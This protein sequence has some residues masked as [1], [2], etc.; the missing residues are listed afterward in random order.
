MWA[1]CSARNLGIIHSKGELVVFVDDTLSFP[2]DWLERM[3]SWYRRGYNPVSIYNWKDP[4]GEILKHNGVDVVDSRIKE[5]DG[6]VVSFPEHGDWF[7]TG[8]GAGASI[9]ALLEVNGFDENFD[10]V[11]SLE[12]S[13]IGIRMFT[14]G[15][16]FV[17]DTDICATNN[18]VIY[19]IGK[20]VTNTKAFKSNYPLLHLNRENKVIAANKRKL[21]Q[22]EIEFVRK[23]TPIRDNQ[24]VVDDDMFKLWVDSQ[25]T[26]ELNE[27]RGILL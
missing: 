7:H 23:E 20:V 18:D 5:L 19:D 13:D 16:K 26:F 11:K 8:G 27:L 12:D 10:G 6:N 15:H 24:I 14:A 3:W 21:T 9:D 17:F 4:N 22:E 25:R 1:L 2:E